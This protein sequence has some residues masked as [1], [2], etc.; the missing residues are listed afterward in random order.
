MQNFS[1]DESSYLEYP[2]LHL[3]AEILSCTGLVR[4][5]S[6]LRVTLFLFDEIELASLQDLVLLWVVIFPS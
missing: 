1:E 5:D 4:R 6:K 2:H 3:R